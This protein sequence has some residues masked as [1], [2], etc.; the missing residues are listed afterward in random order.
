MYK[1]RFYN[2]KI[3]DVVNRWRN[4]FRTPF[5]VM[6]NYT[7]QRTPLPAEYSEMMSAMR[8]SC[9][10]SRFSLLM[11]N[12]NGYYPKGIGG[13]A[14]LSFKLTC[15]FFIRKPD[16]KIIDHACYVLAFQCFERCK[17]GPIVM[18]FLKL[19]LVLLLLNIYSTRGARTLIIKG[20][21]RMFI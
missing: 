1:R 19:S 12:Q 16:Y 7:K 18:C 6:M 9:N 8:L 20:V 3:S 4:D 10:R 11:K 21:G 14:Y 13:R 17:I 2:E 15:S 5:D